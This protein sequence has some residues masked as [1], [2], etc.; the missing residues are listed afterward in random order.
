MS[1]AGHILFRRE[2]A[3]NTV[4]NNFEEVKIMIHTNINKHILKI[5]LT[6]FMKEPVQVNIHSDKNWNM[7]LGR[8][9]E[10]NLH[11]SANIVS[12]DGICNVGLSFPKV[13][14]SC[15]PHRQIC[16]SGFLQV[17]FCPLELCST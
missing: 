15:I 10:M 5:L 8:N 13:E 7:Y 16:A 9:A 4:K 17:N 14:V 12:Y 3:V 2:V 11:L 1:T 6:S